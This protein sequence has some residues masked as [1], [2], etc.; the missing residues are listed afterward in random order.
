MPLVLLNLAGGDS[1]DDIKI[2]DK[3]EGFCKVLSRIETKGLIRP[4]AKG[5]GVTMEEGVPS[6][7]GI[8]Q[9]STIVTKRRSAR[10]ARLSNKHLM[11]VNRDLVASIQR[12]RPKKEATVAENAERG[13]PLLLQGL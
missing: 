11:R 10:R 2:L 3:D 5:A 4:A 6:P 13:R 8:L 9:P 1:V 7:S 12:C